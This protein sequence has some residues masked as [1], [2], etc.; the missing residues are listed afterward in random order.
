M[1]DVMAVE[2]T[3][4][5]GGGKRYFLTYRRQ[6]D[7]A[8]PDPVREHVLEYAR[9]FARSGSLGGEP[10]SARIC[11]TLREAADSSEAP[12][13]YEVFLHLASTPEPDVEQRVQ[14]LGDKANVM[15]YDR[16]VWFC[17]CPG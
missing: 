8:D 3:L 14:L 1:K 16:S 17:G 2:V 13:F 11:Q 15:P 10:V 7:N 12:Y 5:D 6:Q 9:A 4:A